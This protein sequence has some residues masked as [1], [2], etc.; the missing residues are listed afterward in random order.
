[1]PKPSL[2]LPATGRR[3]RAALLAASFA[4]AS[5][6]GAAEPEIRIDDVE[7]FYALYNA[8]D[9]K[10]SVAQLDGY[11]AQGSPSLKEFAQLRRV[12]GERIA[13]QM[14]ADPAV[15]RD[16]R[17]CLALLPKVKRRVAAALRTLGELYPQAKFPPVAIVVGRGK[18]VGI[19]NPSGVTVGL[20]ALCA[21]DFMNPDPEDRF[22]RVI[23]H[24][25]AHIQQPAAA[26][27]LPQGDPR[28][29]VRLM[30]LTEGAAEFVA[31]LIAG[32]VANPGLA[33]RVRGREKEIGEAFLR[34]QD[35]TDYSQW[36]YNYRKDSDGPYDQGYW[37]GYRVAKA[38]YRRAGDK[39][40]ALAEI[41]LMP[42][43]KAFLAESGWK[44]GD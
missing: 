15:Y 7:R 40:A 22:V 38:Y 24:E 12:T 28:A 9:G 32:G 4:I 21:A 2:V 39:R 1:M 30:S 43:P 18:P 44:P 29:N 41:L 11:L 42:D 23:A 37:I 3:L 19:T 13:A 31:E 10:P 33:V 20:E 14:A 16:A 25:Y 17:K 26:E 34:E 8:T 27:E 5:A 6:A 36:M 35:N